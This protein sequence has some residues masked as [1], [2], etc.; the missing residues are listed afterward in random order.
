MEGRVQEFTTLGG[1]RSLAGGVLRNVTLL[2][3][4]SKNRRRYT[5]AALASAVGMFEGSQ[6]FRGHSDQPLNRDPAELLGHVENVRL[7]GGRVRGDLHVLAHQ[8][9][10]VAS[11]ADAPKAGAGMSWDGLAAW[12]TGTDGW[13]EVQQ[14]KNVASIDLVSKPATTT[15]LFESQGTRRRPTCTLDDVIADARFHGR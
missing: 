5:P 3:P 7:D 9:E 14:I 13:Q 8:R 2:G 15:N 1:G 10:F 12:T 11:L 6:V 4:T